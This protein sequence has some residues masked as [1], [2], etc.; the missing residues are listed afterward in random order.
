MDA[1]FS[2]NWLGWLLYTLM[3]RSEYGSWLPVAHFLAE[4][5]DADVV[6]AA[7]KI[8]A[9]WI[10]SDFEHPGRDWPIRYFLTDDS[11]VEQ[12][13]VYEVFGQQVDHLLCS[14]HSE[15]TLRRNFAGPRW[16]SCL[17]HLL[18]ALKARRTSIGCEE[19]INAA[20]AAAERV[21]GAIGKEMADYIFT[22]WMQRKRQWANYAREHS[23]LLLQVRYAVPQAME[24]RIV[25]TLPCFFAGPKHQR[26]RGVPLCPEVRHQEHHAVFF[27]GRDSEARH[28][29][30][31]ALLRPCRPRQVCV[32]HQRC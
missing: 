12:K 22:R 17:N 13:A 24:L 25:L 7:L 23:P 18:A 20:I 6:A 2:T 28:P 15:R 30:Q 21:P 27:S 4:K 26:P 1:T 32:S 29:G 10:R 14:V 31:Q 16:R 5:G 19:S 8:V 3:V 11:A 9:S